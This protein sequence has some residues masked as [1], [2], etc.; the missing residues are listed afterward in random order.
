M[1][2]LKTSSMSYNSTS[3]PILTMVRADQECRML[4]QADLFWRVLNP[5][6]VLCAVLDSNEPFRVN[7]F[8]L[9]SILVS[10]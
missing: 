9:K 10:L 7:R 2:G 4:S 1:R 5:F 3:C 8:Q 6:G